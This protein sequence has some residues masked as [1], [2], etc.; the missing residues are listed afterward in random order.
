VLSTTAQ[1]PEFVFQSGHFE[2]ITCLVFNTTGD[3]LI[4]ASKD[5]TIRVWDLKSR[6]LARIISHF[7]EEEVEAVCY[8]SNDS[9]LISLDKKALI[10]WNVFSGEKLN[11]FDLQNENQYLST[12]HYILIPDK[13]NNLLITNHY[14]GDFGIELRELSSGK[15]IIKL[16]VHENYLTGAAYYENGNAVAYAYGDGTIYS[17]NTETTQDKVL[18]KLPGKANGIGAIRVLNDELFA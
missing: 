17:Y 12:D 5:K 1:V 13:S 8:G 10:Y 7:T 18:I 4:S 15:S 14:D 2:D 11:T 6:R 9:I 16:P 3:Q